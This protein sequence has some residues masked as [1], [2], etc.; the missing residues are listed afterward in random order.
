VTSYGLE[1]L[2]DDEC[3]ELLRAH[4]F[5]RVAIWSG[6]QPAVLPVLYG[7]LDGDIVFRTAP[8]EKLIAAVLGEQVVFEIDAAEPARHTGWSVNVVG[9]AERIVA[10]ADIE[11]AEVL[12]LEPWAGEWRNDYVRIRTERM[13]GRRIRPDTGAVSTGP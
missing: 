8:G 4:S 13:S 7:V 1:I 11:R 9:H 10:Q 2:G 5:G 12:A 6:P 3:L